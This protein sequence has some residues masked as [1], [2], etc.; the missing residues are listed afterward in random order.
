[1][2]G[3]S[4]SKML[5]NMLHYLFMGDKNAVVVIM[6]ELIEV[7]VFLFVIFWLF[8]PRGK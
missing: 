6:V 1:M 8:K 4:E 5:K 2:K 7:N 3:P